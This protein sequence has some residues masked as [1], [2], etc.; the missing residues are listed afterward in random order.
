[1]SQ[2]IGTT[3]PPV[4]HRFSS[5]FECAITYVQLRAYFC[6]SRAQQAYYAFIRVHSWV[7]NNLASSRHNSSRGR[8]SIMSAIARECDGGGIP[9]RPEY[10]SH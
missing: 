8:L 3:S 5:N 7:Y 4:H 9:H 6:E 2:Y 1:M 10:Q